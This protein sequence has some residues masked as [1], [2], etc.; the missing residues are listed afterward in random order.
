MHRFVEEGRFEVSL[1]GWHELARHG[2]TV[3]GPPLATLGVWTD[4]AACG[5]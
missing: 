2:L 3:A 1:V 5:P 4:D